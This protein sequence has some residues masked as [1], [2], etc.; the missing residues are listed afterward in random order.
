MLKEAA[1]KGIFKGIALN[2]NSPSI[3]HL[4]FADDTLIFLD[5]D[6]NSV[7]AEI[8]K[9]KIGSWPMK[10][11]G[12]PVGSSSKRKVF[13]VPLIMKM[14]QKLAS[15]KAES[16]NQAGRLV[17][18]KSVMENLPTHWLSLHRLPK[19][20]L[21][22]LEK[23][24]RDFFWKDSDSSSGGNRRLHLTAWQNICKPKAQGGLGLVPLMIK[25]LSLLGKWSFRWYNDRSRSWNKWIKEKYKC[26]NQG[27]LNDVLRDKK[28][29]NSLKDIWE[30]SE[31]PSFKNILGSNSF[32]WTVRNGA[33][34]LFWEDV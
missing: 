33:S 21:E 30:T 5:K 23:I 12:I 10:Y 1:A 4:Q 8:L 27:S 6:L 17:L 9:C 26:S 20:V 19:S 18:I 28:L 29:S 15:W 7:K 14:R 34:V 32:S 22:Q 3:T 13:W 25:N 16:L 11:L 24:R 31:H 2:N